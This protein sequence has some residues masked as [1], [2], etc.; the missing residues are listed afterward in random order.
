MVRLAPNQLGHTIATRGSKMH[1][2]PL[3]LVIMLVIPLAGCAA[4]MGNE[5]VALETASTVQTKIIEGTTTKADIIRMYGDT[6]AKVYSGGVEIWSYYG[7]QD[8]AGMF[9]VQR[10]TGGLQIV[11]DKAGVVQSYQ[12]SSF[13]P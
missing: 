10:K 12:M 11:F 6:G 9:S 13:T 1:Q 7:M 5:R 3:A 2:L 4:T 8:R